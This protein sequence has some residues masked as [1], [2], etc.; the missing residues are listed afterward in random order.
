M[1]VGEGWVL[2]GPFY[3]HLVTLGVVFACPIMPTSCQH[4]FGPRRAVVCVVTCET[5]CILSTLGLLRRVPLGCCW[6]LFVVCMFGLFP[7]LTVIG[8]GPHQPDNAGCW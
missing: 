5:G 2:K 6:V 1:G 4:F 3:C 8:C 7:L